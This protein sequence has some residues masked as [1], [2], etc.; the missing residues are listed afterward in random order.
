MPE[1][2]RH[3]IVELLA[4]GWIPTATA[5]RFKDGVAE[6]VGLTSTELQIRVVRMATDKTINVFWRLLLRNLSDEALV[7]RTPVLY[8]R[9]FDR[10]ELVSRSLERGRALF[11]LSGWPGMPDYDALGLATGITRVLEHSGRKDATVTWTR[12]ADQVVFEARWPTAD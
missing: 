10:G 4:I 9:T 5:Q 12:R 3:E 8:S 2:Q 7:K 11:E 6:L 1:A